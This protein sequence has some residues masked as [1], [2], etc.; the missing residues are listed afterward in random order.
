MRIRRVT[1][2]LSVGVIT[3]TSLVSTAGA[4]GVV[5]PANP[6]SEVWALPVY[7][8]TLRDHG[9]LKA[10]GV[11]PACWGW[12]RSLAFVAR[13]TAPHCVAEELAATN[14]AHHSEGLGNIGLPRNFIKLSAADQMLVITDIERVSR[15]EDPVLGIEAPL[16]AYAQQ[17][18]VGG[19]DPVVG[20]MS[21]IDGATGGFASNYAAGV[22]ALDANYQ[23]MYTD[24]WDGKLT[25]NG[26]CTSAVAPGCW[27]HRDNILLNDSRMACQVATCSFVMGAG[28][29]NNG[30]HDGY[31][32]FS[33]LFVQI[34]GVTPVLSYTW[35]EAVAAG[36]HG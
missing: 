2:A 33:E 6:H 36:A 20:S 14:W 31:S 28:F 5:P 18:A 34:S 4:S 9:L 3:V 32:S 35:A 25:T 11:L 17:G 23:W 26:D 22:N 7:S 1:T 29:V 8:F 30:R 15:G 27:G 24:G 13:P 21:S 19:Y 12:G 10:G 16:N